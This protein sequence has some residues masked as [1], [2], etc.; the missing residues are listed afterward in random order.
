MQFSYV[1][2]FMLSLSNYLDYNKF[3]RYIFLTRTHKFDCGIVQKV[4]ANYNSCFIVAFECESSIWIQTEVVFFCFCVV[5][6]V[7]VVIAFEMEWIL[8]ANENLVCNFVSIE[9]S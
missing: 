2:I 3:S 5:V 1:N 4:V 9:K 6:V 8:P 7:A